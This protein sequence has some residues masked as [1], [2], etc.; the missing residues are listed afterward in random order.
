MDKSKNLTRMGIRL[1]IP[2]S[3]YFRMI[4]NHYKSTLDNVL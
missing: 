3:F 2:Y 4:I 1:N